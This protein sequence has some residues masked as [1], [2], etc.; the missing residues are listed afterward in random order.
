MVG[1]LIQARLGSSRLPGKTMLPLTNNLLV[2]DA[3]YQRCKMSNA[4]SKVVICISN[5]YKDD[6][7]AEYLGSKKIEFFRGSEENLTLRFYEACKQYNLSSFIRVTG[8]NPLVD[9]KLIDSF[10][11]LNKEY[12]F[13]NGYSPKLLPNG[14]VISRINKSLLYDI[15]NSDATLEELEHVVTSRIANNESYSYPVDDEFKYPEA[16]YCLDVFEDYLV[17]LE[18]F[19]NPGILS[20]NTKQIVEIYNNS[21]KENWE[22]ARRGY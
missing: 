3:V 5:S 17:L 12:R 11:S 15:L 9:P 4:T 14:T 22:Y 8:D 1:I 16:R 18:L 10:I 6:G 2:V 19:K 21:K 13:I 20:M 7:L